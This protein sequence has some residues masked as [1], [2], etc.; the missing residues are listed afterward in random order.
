[1][2]STHTPAGR[3]GA[4]VRTYP[5]ARILT[6]GGSRGRRSRPWGGRARGSGPGCCACCR[7]RS[8]RPVSCVAG[9]RRQLPPSCAP[10]PR[11]A[12]RC[13]ASA[14][15]PSARADLALGDPADVVLV[16]PLRDA[17]RL[18]QVAVVGLDEVDGVGHRA[19][20]GG[21]PNQSSV[22]CHASAAPRRRGTTRARRSGT[23]ARRPRSGRSRSS[24][25][26]CVERGAQL[27][28]LLDRDRLPSWSPNSPSHGVCS[29]RRLADERR[30]LREPL[31]HD[32]AAVEADRGTER[33]GAGAARNVTRPPKQKPDDADLAV[34][35]ARRAGGGRASRRGP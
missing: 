19:A 34:G 13:R 3:I 2:R 17:R 21:C 9:D 29:R 12:A 5:R 20:R 33:R 16:E 1:M 22:R 4:R 31:V 11:P 30:E 32:A 7:R 14:R 8:A 27:L 25:G 26:A 15:R 18:A 28:D 24:T 35:E 6:S 10:S 23:R